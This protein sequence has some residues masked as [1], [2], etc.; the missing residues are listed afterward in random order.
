VEVFCDRN[1]VKGG[2]NGIKMNI[3]LLDTRFYECGSSLHEREVT[4]AENAS[5]HT[6][7]ACK[8]FYL[9]CAR[10]MRTQT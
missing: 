10:Y 1:E 2:K 9:A 7:L 4:T 5:F 3:G 8:R 6:L